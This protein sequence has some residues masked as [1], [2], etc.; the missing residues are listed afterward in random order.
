MA[1]S[2]VGYKIKITG[3]S[4]VIELTTVGSPGS[5][6]SVTFKMNTLDDHSRNRASDIRC[7]IVL[8]GSIQADTLDATVSLAKWS[9]DANA[10]SIYRSVELEIYEDAECTGKLLR[11]YEVDDMF[12]LDYSEKFGESTENGTFTLFIAQ[13]E[14]AAEKSKRREVYSI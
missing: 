13:K 12:V 11:R 6:K 4:E 5:L 3:G 14:G 8:E 7:E 2:T 1:S 10:K 9:M